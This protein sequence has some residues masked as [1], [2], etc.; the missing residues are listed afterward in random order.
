M[1]RCRPLLAAL[2]FCVAACGEPANTAPVESDTGVNDAGSAF[3]DLARDI[4]AA[5]GSAKCQD[6]RCHGGPVGA[7]GLVMGSDARGIYDGLVGYSSKVYKPSRVVEP[8]PGGD[9]RPKSSLLK[10]IGPSPPGSMPT[11]RPDLGNRRLTADELAR[12]EAWLARGA[13]FD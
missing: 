2:G 8:V 13:P 6:A 10:I 4:F 11:V 5:S 9:A 1:R 12:V 3:N 7:G